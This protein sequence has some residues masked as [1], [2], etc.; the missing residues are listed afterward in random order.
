MSFPAWLEVAIILFII[1]GI[2]LVVWKSGAANPVATGGLNTRLT[3][4]DQELKGVRRQ[5]D[6]IEERVEK[7]SGMFAKTSDIRRVEKG[8]ELNAEKMDKV[9]S[10][11]AAVREE[12]AERG[13]TGKATARLLDIIHKEIVSKGMNS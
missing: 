12:A 3:T 1:G 11:I 9:M 5:V 2:S 13:A 8:L 6:E 4:V 10:E 7:M